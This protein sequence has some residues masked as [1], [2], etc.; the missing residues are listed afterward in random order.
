MVSIISVD[1]GMILECQSGKYGG[2]TR[3]YF[4]MYE[5]YT[6]VDALG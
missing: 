1:V 6:P 3:T 2:T 5:V 4:R